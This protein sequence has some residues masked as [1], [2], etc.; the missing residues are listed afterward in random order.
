MVS[1]LGRTPEG[2]APLVYDNIGLQYGLV[3]LEAGAITPEQFVDLNARVGGWDIDGRWQPRRSAMDTAT[4]ALLHRTGQVT[5]GR[6]SARVAELVVRGTDNNDY[7]YPFRTYVQRARLT[8]A[9]GHADNHTSWTAPPDTLSTLDA[10]DRW[11]DAVQADT[12]GDPLEDR[13]VRNR[14][15]DQVPACWIQGARVTEASRCDAAY[16]YFR[17]PRTAAGDRPT[18][19]TMKCALKPLERSD[20]YVEFSD[21]QWERLS[22]VFARGVCDYAQPPVGFQPN[23]PWLT[24]ADGPGGRPLG[25]APESRPFP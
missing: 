22:A 2:I 1:V 18:I 16:P 20:Y 13:I 15:A 25:P 6:E 14:P 8:A 7:H 23:Q 11:L 17:E 24:Y 12:R 5:F 19:Y 9:N 21:E 4:A 10:M 3:A